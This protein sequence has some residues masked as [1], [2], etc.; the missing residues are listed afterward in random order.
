MP[1]FTYKHR[2][3]NPSQGL[4]PSKPRGHTPRKNHFNFRLKYKF[5]CPLN[6]QLPI[7]LIHSCCF[8][9]VSHVKISP[10]AFLTL[11]YFW[12]FKY[13]HEYTVSHNKTHSHTHKHTLS[14]AERAILKSR[15]VIERNYLFNGN[16]IIS[17]MMNL[18][19]CS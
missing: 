3:C 13:I 5:K 4:H 16:S 1:D 11:A 10:F 18:L 8:V 19:I 6:C 12:E 7:P 15:K 17:L 9:F 2:Q 14:H